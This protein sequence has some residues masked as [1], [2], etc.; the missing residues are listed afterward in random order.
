MGNIIIILSDQQRWDTVGCYVGNSVTPNIDRMA[1][2]GAFFAN[3]FTPQPVCGPARACIQTGL[4]ATQTGCFV[5]DVPLREQAVTFPKLLRAQGYDTAYVGKWH[6]ASA[7]AHGEDYITNAPPA[8]RRG[9]FDYWMA[10][11]ALELTSDAYS[12]YVFNTDNQ[13]VSFDGYRVN[14]IG[15]FALDYLDTRKNTEKP[16]LLFVSFIEP[17]QQNSTNLVQPPID[18]M[19][20]LEYGI[21]KDFV[22]GVGNWACNL[23]AYMQCCRRIDD[24]VGKIIDRTK[25]LNLYKD[26]LF[27]YTSDHGCHFN[28]RCKDYKRT[29]HDASIRIPLVLCGGPFAYM[30]RRNDFASLV[31]IAPTILAQAGCIIPSSMVGRN[32]AHRN[33]EEDCAYVQIS[34]RCVARAIRTPD[35]CYCVSNRHEDPIRASFS[36]VYEE[37]FLYDL[38]LDPDEMN[39]VIAAVEYEGVRGVLRQKLMH[40]ALQAGEFIESIQPC[41]QGGKTGA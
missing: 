33:R 27:L 37:A 25:Q 9:G 20:P 35:F 15:D 28:T 36:H 11:D 26:T 41:G 13:K 8:R 38:A 3:A 34:E 23:E 16:F 4:Y 5:N 1:E 40:C 24:Y 30:G 21:P 12:G 39:N 2:E 6:L 19:E 18:F 32:L 14:A 17:H 10:S 29:C 7:V 31:D 22:E